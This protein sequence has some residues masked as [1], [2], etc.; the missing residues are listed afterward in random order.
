MRNNRFRLLT[1]KEVELRV[2]T[3]KVTNSVCGCSLLLYK[4]ARCDMAILDET[5]GCMGWK[6]DHIVINGNLYC[7]VSI[8]NE[9]S[10]E[11]ITKQDVG[12]ESYTD[13]EKGQS[14]DSFKRACVNW[15]IGR[16]LY[17]AP[18]VWINLDMDEVEESGTDNFGKKKYRVKSKVVFKVK[19]IGY[20]ENRE[21]NKLVIV[22]TKNNVRFVLAPP[23]EP[24]EP[25]E[26]PP[27]EPQ[28]KPQEQEQKQVNNSPAEN[29]KTAHGKL[30]TQKQVNGLYKIAKEKG[31]SE[32]SVLKCAIKKYQVES[33]EQLTR[34]QYD[35]MCNGYESLNGHK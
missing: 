11:W 27:Q 14:S 23:Q 21:I 32:A 17:T 8:Y 29:K 19:E 10:K 25:Q 2:S 16:E 1:A 7:N 15:G 31:F 18:F 26:Q 20:N 6:R 24:Q 13:K 33:L 28:N 34:S 4:N 5:F 12:T 9:E 35:E 3:V 22:D 30:L